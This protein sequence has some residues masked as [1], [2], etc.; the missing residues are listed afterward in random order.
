M[1]SRLQTLIITVPIRFRR[2]N[3]DRKKESVI[4]DLPREIV[5]VASEV[6]P[7]V[8]TGGL[9]DVV[10]AL[11]RS[12]VDLGVKISVIA[13]R[14][15]PTLALP[16]RKLGVMYPVAVGEKKYP[17]ELY[18]AEDPVSRHRV[19]LL[20]QPD[21]FDRPGLYVDDEGRDYP[22]NLQ[23]FHLLS[24]GALLAIDVLEIPADV[25]HAHDWQTGLLP[26]Y[27]RAR[28]QSH[29][30]LRRTASVFT[31]HNVVFQGIFSRSAGAAIGL[32][33]AE[34]KKEILGYFRQISLLKG[35]IVR[36]DFVTTVSRQYA[37]ELTTS[38]FGCGMQ[39]Y[40]R[41]R[42]DRFRGI[43]N[44][45][46]TVEFDPETDRALP[47]HYN[48]ANWQEGKTACKEALL[49]AAADKTKPWIGMV[50]RLTEQKGFDL[51]LEV[52]DEL[53][54]A[55][56]F[57]WV[58]LGTGDKKYEDALGALAEKY[59]ASLTFYC[60]FD[61]MLARK[62]YAATDLFLMPSRFEP[63][64]LAQ[65]YA[66]RYG[67][68]PIV[69]AVGGLI[70]TVVAHNSVSNPGTGFSFSEY[71]AGALCACL[72]RASQAWENPVEWRSIVDRGMSEDWS[73]KQ[74]A[75]QYLDVYRAAI[76]GRQADLDKELLG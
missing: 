52:A 51:V 4:E 20:D 65:L 67:S 18:E 31:I 59:P 70:D 11:P 57:R 2:A 25:I 10:G 71:S 13:P 72:Q 68:V 15:R 26:I 58:I 44:G 66:L 29:P 60:R 36:S 50:G 21:F 39:N 28:Y 46:D 12:L 55:D 17:V 64:G 61:E 73:W 48:H 5:F 19:L 33:S 32:S 30:L 53:L 74:A 38:E 54:A 56:S 1:E 37:K 42:G 41:D 23:R 63:C 27:L 43:V 16:Q 7:F 22:D 9:G 14:F 49:G 47:V 62:I 75:E 3:G 24:L 40:L 35:G 69:H 8:K 34:L 45:I 6:A 76:A